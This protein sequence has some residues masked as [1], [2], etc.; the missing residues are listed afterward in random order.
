MECFEDR[1]SSFFQK[2]VWRFLILLRCPVSVCIFRSITMEMLTLATDDFTSLAVCPFFNAIHA[3]PIYSLI[4]VAPSLFV[5]PHRPDRIPGNRFCRCHLFSYCCTLS[6][7]RPVFVLT[8]VSSLCK[9]AAARCP[10]VGARNL[11]LLY[12]FSFGARRCVSS[13]LFSCLSFRLNRS[14]TVIPM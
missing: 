12:E 3:F 10:W 13:V 6:F 14:S 5:Y 1:Y 2:L 8:I 11:F 9:S 4:L 7:E